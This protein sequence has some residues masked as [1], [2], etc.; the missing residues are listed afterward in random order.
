MQVKNGQVICSYLIKIFNPNDDDL[1]AQLDVLLPPDAVVDGYALD[2]DGEMVDGVVIER[3]RAQRILEAEERKNIDPATIEVLSGNRFRVR[4]Y[5]VDA[6]EWR[7]VRIDFSAPLVQ[8][9]QRRSLTLHAP[10]WEVTG[11][12]SFKIQSADKSLKVSIGKKEQSIYKQE[13]DVKYVSLIDFEKTVEED[14]IDEHLPVTVSLTALSEPSV[15]VEKNSKGSFVSIVSPLIQRM[16]E[17]GKKENPTNR[18]SLAIAWDASGSRTAADIKLSVSF[19]RLLFNRWPNCRV[20]VVVFRNTANERKTFALTN[21]NSDSLCAWLTARHT[22]GG[23]QLNAIDLRAK[24]LPHESN[25]CWLWFCDGIGTSGLNLPLSD[26]VPVY[27]LSAASA[28]NTTVL[29]IL[30]QR[31]GGR[32]IT[33]HRE[34]ISPQIDLLINPHP[35]LKHIESEGVLEQA[36]FSQNG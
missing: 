23:T 9:A 18:K 8:I 31:S 4:I 10:C 25:E 28:Q 15:L 11:E 7:T 32:A 33:L 17:N 21:G 27:A 30:A 20:D 13:Q 6:E 16:A 24:G 29:K 14:F 2:I 35:F 12:N 3:S 5:P 36:H 26:A 1:E 34:N 22:D 19:L